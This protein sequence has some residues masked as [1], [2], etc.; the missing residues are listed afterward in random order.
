MTQYLIYMGNLLTGDL[1]QSISFSS[2][3]SEVLRSPPGVPALL[4]AIVLLSG[5]D[6]APHAAAVG[7][8]VVAC[9]RGGGSWTC[10]SAGPVPGIAP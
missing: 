8:A 1:G 4:L 10:G 2:P 9:T 7:T 3:V 6:A 5:A